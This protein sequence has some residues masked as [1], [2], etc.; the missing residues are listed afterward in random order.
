MTLA[1]LQTF[2]AVAEAG[3][4]RAAA[5]RLMV[6]QSAVST[7]LAALQRSLGLKLIDR[8]G[9]GIRLT[10]AGATYA[11]YVRRIF[12]LLD[13]ARN[14]AAGEAGIG[15]D[16]LRI[17]AVTTVG[18]QILPELLTRF[19]RRYPR[20]GIRLS[21]TNQEHAISLLKN[22]DVDLIITGAATQSLRHQR[23]ATHGVRPYELILVGPAAARTLLAKRWQAIRPWLGTQ[24]WLLREPGSAIQ[25]VTCDLLADI[26]LAPRTLSLGSNSTIREAVIAGLG[27]SLLARETVARELANGSLVEIPTPLTPLRQMWQLASHRGQLPQPAALFVRHLLTDGGFTAPVGPHLSTTNFGHIKLAASA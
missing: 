24:T 15:T 20:T 25:S 21:V 9:R 1:Q 3:S 4:V 11:N 23:T 22:H 8:D 18:E 17:A 19:Q 26:Q 2:L 12:R 5:E 6:T 14:A 10:D 7:S 16:E 13:E 27:V